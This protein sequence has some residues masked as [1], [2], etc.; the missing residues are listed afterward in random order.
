MRKKALLVMAHGGH[1]TEMLLLDE[2]L[3]SKIEICYL[4]LKE[5]QFTPKKVQG[6]IFRIFGARTKKSG[7]VHDILGTLAMILQSLWI[8][9]KAK[10]DAIISCGT[11]SA[12]PI[13]YL[14]KILGKKV[15]FIESISRV[16]KHS[17]SGQLIYPI[18][19][20]FFVQWEAMKHIYPKAIYA[21]RLQ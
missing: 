3:K 10:P 13:S 14:G 2:K 9:I 20:L 12:V 6:E 17:L 19:D 18:A 5:D 1:T 7:L 11:S 21:G 16:Y 15:I 4:I 8:F